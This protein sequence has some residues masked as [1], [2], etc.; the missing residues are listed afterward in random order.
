MNVLVVVVGVVD[1]DFATGIANI[2]KEL[3]FSVT[4]DPIHWVISV[5]N[6]RHYL[7][8]C[9]VR[10]IG[11]IRQALFFSHGDEKLLAVRI[12]DALFYVV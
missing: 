5:I 7:V 1:C 6:E 11:I 12:N 10:C 4:N 3:A 8:K 2:C 9:V